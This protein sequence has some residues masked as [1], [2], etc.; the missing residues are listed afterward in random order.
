MKEC[1]AR[2]ANSRCP[3]EATGR[4]EF[5]LSNIY[6]EQGIEEEEAERLD[7]E[8]RKILTKYSSTTPEYLRGVED[9][10]MVFDEMQP[11]ESGRFTG[12]GLLPHMQSWFSSTDARKG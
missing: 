12:R 9:K 2:A 4:V 6:R 11:V 3:E 5:H 1:L 7:Q 10:I 8:A